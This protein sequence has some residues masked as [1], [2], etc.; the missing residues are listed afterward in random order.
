WAGEPQEA[1]ERE[2][3]SHMHGSPMARLY[4]TARG[5]FA[6]FLTRDAALAVLAFVILFKLCDAL[7]GAMTAPFVLSLGYTKAEYAAIVKGVGLAALLVG[8]FAGGAVAR[9]LPMLSALWIAAI[10]QMLSNLVFVWLGSQET[11]PWS[12]TVAIVVENFSGAI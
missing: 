11:S 5:A 9:A 3:E 2:L 10:I 4:E 7:A 12:L 8:G 6:D 1:R